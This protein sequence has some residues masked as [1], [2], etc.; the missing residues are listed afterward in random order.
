M[1][2][3]TAVIVYIFIAT[4]GI[5]IY[6][7]IAFCRLQKKRH[8]KCPHCGY[9]FKPGGLTAYFSKRENVT[10]RLL[11]CP[12]CGYRCFMKNIEDGKEDTPDNMQKENTHG[13]NDW[14]S[15]GR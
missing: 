2:P 6:S 8:Y 14:D 4:F 12:R 9:S 10:D 15:N 1:D 3:A 7:M 11:D 5:F 13:D